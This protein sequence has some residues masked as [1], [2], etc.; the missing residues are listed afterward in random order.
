MLV[1]WS[2]WS[3]CSIGESDHRRPNILDIQSV[4]QDNTPA[5]PFNAAALAIEDLALEMCDRL[6]PRMDK[7]RDDDL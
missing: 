1:L 2:W 4:A 6:L 7:V 3:W 5:A